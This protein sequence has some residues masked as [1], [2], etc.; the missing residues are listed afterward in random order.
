M[1]N[2]PYQ[3]LW[4]ISILSEIW[5]VAFSEF[6]MHSLWFLAVSAGCVHLGWPLFRAR[7]LRG[8]KRKHYVY[9][10]YKIILKDS[11]I[12]QNVQ[13]LVFARSK[14]CS[15]VARSVPS[16][17]PYLELPP[18]RWWKVWSLYR[19]LKICK[20]LSGLSFWPCTQASLKNNSILGLNSTSLFD[21]VLVPCK[22]EAS[23]DCVNI[24]SWFGLWQLQ[25]PYTHQPCWRV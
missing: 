21:F 16:L 18:W 10:N 6:L 24:L 9:N 22:C 14:F 11:H 1:L 15:V 3:T 19:K 5:K 2:Q 8:V 17:L 7:S 13:T 25:L 23:Q 20:F 4:I 12:T